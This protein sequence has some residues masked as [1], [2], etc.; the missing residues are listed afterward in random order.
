MG[1]SREKNSYQNAKTCLCQG[2]GEIALIVKLSVPEKEAIIF[3]AVRI[4]DINT[5]FF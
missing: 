5:T 4:S 3:T 2:M 1:A